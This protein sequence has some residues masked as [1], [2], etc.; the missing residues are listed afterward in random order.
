MGRFLYIIFFPQ[1]V[2]GL[3]RRAENFL[4]QI[5]L[6]F[7]NEVPFVEAAKWIIAGY[8][9][10]LLSLTPNTLTTNMDYPLYHALRSSDRWLCLFLYSYQIYAHFLVYPPSHRAG[11]AAATV[12]QSISTCPYISQFVR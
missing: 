1:L 3:M 8:F 2:S 10:K 6:K 12:C 11:A 9:F 4:P 5:Q 7:L